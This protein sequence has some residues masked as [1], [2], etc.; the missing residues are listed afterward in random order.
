MSK[1]LE[2]K[3]HA[4]KVTIWLTKH[5][6]KF[7]KDMNRMKFLFNILCNCQKNIFLQGLVSFCHIN[8]NFDDFKSLRLTETSC[9][10]SGSEIP[11][12][13]KRLDFLDNLR[14]Q[15]KGIDFAEH[16]AWIS[17]WIQN[18]RNYKSRIEAEEFM[19]RT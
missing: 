2:D 10:W 8:K 14:T 4:P 13:D 7:G 12:I 11:L 17:E 18:I 19:D 1:S 15:L 9:A 5:I 16:R 3:D 6:S